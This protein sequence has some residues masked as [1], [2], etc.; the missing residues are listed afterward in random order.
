MRKIKIAAAQIAP[1]TGDIEQ[2][3]LKHCTLIRQAAEHGADLVFF[4]ELS[5]TG[6]EPRLAKELAMQANDPRFEIFQQLSE[7]HKLVIGLGFPLLA[8]DGIRISMLFF[9]AGQAPILYSKQHLHIDE[10]P[11]FVPGKE[12]ILLKINGFTLAPAICYESLLMEHA[13]RVVQKGAEIYI[14][15]VAKSSNGLAKAAQ[16]YALLTRELKLIVVMANSVGPA[17]DFLSAGGSG[18]WGQQVEKSLG[19][20]VDVLLIVELGRGPVIRIGARSKI[21]EN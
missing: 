20:E 18:Y 8:M 10:L 6:Y 11:F 3:I 12:K 2:N 16:H 4:P 1:I 9:Q 19:D 13:D 21:C 15:S 7:Q 5:L 14:A 17:D